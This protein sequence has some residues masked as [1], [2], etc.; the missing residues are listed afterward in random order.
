[1]IDFLFKSTLSLAL[2]FALYFFLLEKEKMHQFNRFFLLASLLFA[3]G[4]PFVSFEIYVERLAVITQE[5][6]FT[7][8]SLTVMVAEKTNYFPIILWSVY[9]LVTLVLAIRFVIH[10]IKIRQKINSNPK[11]PITN[12]T[13]VLLQEKVLPHTFG[14]YIFINGEDHQNSNIEAELYTHE[15]THVRQ[16]HTLDILFVEILKTIFWF[17]PIF[18]LYKK[19]IQLNHE[20]LADEKV[21]QSFNNVPFYQKILLEKASW[22][23]TFYLASNLNFLVTKKRLIMMTKN[24]SSHAKL[25]K[26]LIIIPMSIFTAL[27]ACKTQNTSKSL[28]LQTKSVGEGKTSDEKIY[29]I[30][31]KT[32]EF[33]GGIQAFYEFVGANFK[34]P[35]DFK[36]KGRIFMQFIVET[37]GSLSDI[38][39]LRDIGSGMGDEAKRVLKICPKWNPGENGGKPVRVQYSLPIS[40]ASA[41]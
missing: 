38:T 9:G 11:V 22:N 4:I 17:N 7:S 26:I 20:F 37:D 32:P 24:T 13:L 33:P 21:V 3:L 10:L 1:M 19:A 30:V 39:T 27:V 41:N 18:I 25:L 31:S 40:I 16:N 34:V 15:L 28:D 23:N 2:L 6:V 12:A 29:K 36:G 35:S 8:P 5:T 14:N